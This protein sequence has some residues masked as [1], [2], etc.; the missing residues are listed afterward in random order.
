MS[1]SDEQKN[2]V[3]LWLQENAPS[4]TCPACGNK[5]F[6][7]EN[8]ITVSMGLDVEGNVDFSKGIPVVP[9]T[10]KRCGFVFEF[11]AKQIG[12]ME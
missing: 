3:Q 2:Q 9:V 10:C 1:L 6:N 12:L 11:A 4:L 7:L 5:D 8:M